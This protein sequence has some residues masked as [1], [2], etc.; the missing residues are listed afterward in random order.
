MRAPSFADQ[1]VYNNQRVGYGKECIVDAGSVFGA[2]E[3]LLQPRVWHA[4]VHLITQ[5]VP[6]YRGWPWV[7]ICQSQTTSAAQLPGLLTIAYA[8]LVGGLLVP[9]IGAMTWR[10]GTGIGAACSMLAGTV[11]TLGTMIYL[12]ITAENPL[13]GVFANEPIYFGLLASAVV[14]IVGSLLSKPTPDDVWQA[15]KHRSKHGVQESDDQPP[16]A[17]ESAH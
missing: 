7:L 14:F 6:A 9:I 4:L 11:V 2:Y 17:V 15:W 12:E 3:E 1:A 13:D 16:V 8:I 5:R 10:R